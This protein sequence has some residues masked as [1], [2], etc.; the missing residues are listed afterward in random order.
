MARGVAKSA[1][2]SRRSGR[3]RKEVNYLEERV[4]DFL[5]GG[6]ESRT[7]TN[8]KAASKATAAYVPPTEGPSGASFVSARSLTDDGSRKRDARG[9]VVFDDVPD[10]RPNLTPMQ[11]IRAGI[12]GGCYFNPSGGKK[13][14]RYPKG[15]IPIDHTEYPKSW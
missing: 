1:S 12:F 9:C 11:M 2:A 14:V 10:F 4:D 13:G 5:A 15:G 6:I 7:A 3:K 8:S